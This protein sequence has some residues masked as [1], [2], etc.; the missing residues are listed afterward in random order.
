MSRPRHLSGQSP[1]ICQ[2]RPLACLKASP[3][4]L[5][6]RNR[7]ADPNTFSPEGTPSGK[8]IFLLRCLNPLSQSLTALPAPPRG[9][10]MSRDG[11]QQ[12]FPMMNKLTRQLDKGSP[13]GRAGI[14]QAMTERVFPIG[15]RGFVLLKSHTK[16]GCS[17]NAGSCLC[18]IVRFVNCLFARQRL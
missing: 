14:A 3:G 9:S 13:F 15:R 6:L 17:K 1:S 10:F 8:C 11:K 5:L 12:S 18:R 7:R 4:L 2:R 16:R